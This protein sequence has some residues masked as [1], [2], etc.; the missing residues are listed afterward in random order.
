M[1]LSCL[2]HMSLGIGR[3]N[4]REWDKRPFACDWFDV[5]NMSPDRDHALYVRPWRSGPTR[6]LDGWWDKRVGPNTVVARDALE[7]RASRWQVYE[8][9][10]PLT[11][12]GADK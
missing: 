11:Q 2:T 8:L 3:R 4:A 7:R 1:A 12:G 9:H 5:W 6:K 10:E